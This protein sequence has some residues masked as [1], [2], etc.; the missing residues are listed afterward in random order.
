MKTM[1]QTAY[2]KMLHS[3]EL[4]LAQGSNSAQMSQELWDF[5]AERFN[6]L[7]IL[8]TIPVGISSLMTGR[9]P[10]Q[11]PG[12]EPVFFEITTVG[13]ALSAILL[14]FVAGLILG[15]FYYIVVSQASLSGKVHWQQAMAQWP[16]A[17]FQII[18]L[19]CLWLGVFLLISVPA[20]CIISLFVMSGLPLGQITLFLYMGILLWLFFPIF[21]SAHGIIVYRLHLLASVQFSVRLTRLTL[22]GTSLFFVMMFVISELLDIIWRLPAE[23]SW[24]TL[25]GIIGHAFV[26][27]G[28]LAASFVYYRDSNQWLQKTLG[29][30]A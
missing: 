11:I 23:D 26:T 13:K 1:V 15:T 2:E 21:F 4:T 28:L 8:R 14:I 24:F 18:L 10:I 27:T 12:G 25:I 7:T 17:S 20:S 29:V 16:A 6:L 30:A 19:A 9:S 3:S 22:P 5:I